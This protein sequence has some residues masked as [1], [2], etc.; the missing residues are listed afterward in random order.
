VGLRCVCFVMDALK[1]I[2]VILNELFKNL[3]VECWRGLVLVDVG[4]AF[5]VRSLTPDVW[6]PMSYAAQNILY[7]AL[8]ELNAL[9]ETQ[10]TCVN[11]VVTP[12]V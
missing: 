6:A 3:F 12:P 11:V 2:L 7:R 4:N 9:R 5:G 8:R 1:Q 10:R